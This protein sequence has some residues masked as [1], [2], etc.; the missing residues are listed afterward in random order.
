MVTVRVCSK[1]KQAENR[2]FLQIKSG[3]ILDTVFSGVFDKTIIP[4]ALVGY[5]MIIAGLQCHAIQ[6]RSK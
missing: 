1:L 5:E 6:N 2:L 3:R 4:P